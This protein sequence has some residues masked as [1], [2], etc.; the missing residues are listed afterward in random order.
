MEGIEG[1]FRVALVLL[2]THEEALLACD[3]FEQIMD[4]MK[5]SLPNLRIPQMGHIM[6][7]VMQRTIL[8]QGF[9]SVAK[10]KFDTVMIT[11]WEGV[12]KSCSSCSVQ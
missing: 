8:F 6:S 5:T 3:S 10:E 11:E 7:Q 12:L 4:Y 2:R 1:V 9:V